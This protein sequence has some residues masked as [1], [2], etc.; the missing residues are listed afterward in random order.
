MTE[1]PWVKA[2]WAPRDAAA[3]VAFRIAFGLLV[4]VSAVRFLAYG[5]IDA[6]FLQPTFR[7]HYFGFAW[8]PY[9]GAG[10]VKALFVSLVV[11]GLLVAAGALYRLASLALFVCFSW[12]QLLDV[13][14]YLNHYYLV[15]LLA[16]L[17]ALMPLNRAFSVDAW[18]RPSQRSQTLPAWC[19]WLLRFQ[20]GTVYVFAGL[21]KVT[22]DWL[23]HAQPL[24][25]WLSARSG[26]PVIGPWL[27]KPWVAML[28]SWG[29]FLF[30][31]TIVVWLSWRRTRAL[32]YLAV[33]GFHAVTWLLFPIGMFPW[34]MVTVALVFF[35]PSWPRALWARVR[36]VPVGSVDLERQP[37]P[38]WAPVAVALGLGW[39]VVQLVLPLRAHAYGT[40]VS[41]HEQ[42]MRF[43]WRVMSREKN[44]SVT[45]VVRE[46]V[47][48]REWHVSPKRYLTA[49]QEREMS[50]QPDLV[51]QLAHRIARDFAAEG[52]EVEVRADAWASLNGRPAVRLLN[53]EV[54][55]AAQ[56]DGVGPKTW[57][58]P[59]PAGPPVRLKPVVA[60]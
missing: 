36:R 13:S 48:G 59:A 43:S 33:L 38:R 5:W 4:T 20:V 7:F 16:F 51:L 9:P 50:V 12:V 32:A 6:L 23:L 39:C 40:D 55:L 14:S 21:A 26:A 30:D 57:I 58:T 35:D 54:N 46:V 25:I 56:I 27:E 15:S 10:G 18:L 49:V 31:F 34:I 47:G 19:T 29:G 17:L 60:R 3:L 52:K 44:G 22:S 28:A 42:G 24:S 53:P 8:V 45:F 37:V 41:W 1:S 2:A 11:L